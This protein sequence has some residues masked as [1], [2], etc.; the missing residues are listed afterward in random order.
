MSA[1]EVVAPLDGWCVPLAQVPDPVFAERMAG[2]GVAIDPTAGIV[3]APFDGLIVASRLAHAVTV[4]HASGVDLLVHVGVETVALKGEGFVALAAAGASVRAGEPVLR[5]DLDL[6]ARRARTALTPVIVPSAGHIVRRLEHARVGAR[7]VV[8]AIEPAA[9]AHGA[10]AQAA[11]ELRRE[12]AIPFEHGLH[13]RPAAQLAAAL[14]PF[15]ADVVLAFR[16]RS[17]NARSTVAAMALGVRCGD[18]VEVQASGAGAAAAIEALAGLLAAP[19]AHVVAASVAAPS[20]SNRIAGVVA[21]RG[22]AVGVAAPWTQAEPVVAEA[23]RGAPVEQPALDRALGIVA[24]HLRRLAASASGERK[25]LLAAH[26]ELVADPELARAASGWMRQGK[27]AGDAWRRATRAMQETLAASP[28]PRMA[29]RAADLRDIETQVLRVLAGEPPVAARELAPGSIVLADDIAPSQLLSVDASCLAGLALARGGPTSHVALIAAASGIP[30]IVA[31]GPGVLGIAAGTPLLLDAERGFLDIDPPP[32]AVEHAR[33]GASERNA[34][35]AAERG[36]ANDPALTR[37]GVRIV[38]KANLGSADEAA[39]AAELGA[40]GCGL[41]RTEFLFLD[42]REPPAEDEQLA[43]YQRIAAALSGRPI[44]IRVLDAGGDKPIAYLPMP[45]EENPAL[46][47]RGL[48]AL[49][50][51][52]DLLRP[53]LRAA[54]RAGAPGQCRILLPMVNEPGELRTVRALAAACAREIGRDAPPPIGVMIETPAAA[55]LAAELAAEADFFSLG[56]N[57][58]SQYTLAMDRGHRDLARRFDPVHPAVLR[59]ISHAVEAAHARGKRV[60]VC[61]A[62]GSDVDAIPLLLGLAI[63]EISAIPALVPR[64]KAAIRE[65][66][67]SDCRALARRALELDSAAAVRE[68]LTRGT[69]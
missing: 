62:V 39:R 64:L 18:V 68:L 9:Q 38:V 30:A 54:M 56:T 65:L 22:I 61:G 37:D 34:R 25:T 16:G 33:R 66:S 45:H 17:A 49:I 44:D 48:R 14:K 55:L 47:M 4:R 63:D 43:H 31:A 11:V 2:D 52:P 10:P 29:E 19:P 58:L 40:E 23:G 12:F 5:F 3:R 24:E 53:Q 21:S 60:S 67:L 57:D 32:A 46:G 15:D 13:V 50:D 59:L 8:M 28:E 20:T 41:L 69:S 6:V 36:A 42:R 7:D 51:R 27:S 35:L 1:I 26:A